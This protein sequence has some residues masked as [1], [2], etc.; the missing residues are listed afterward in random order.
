MSEIINLFLV[1]ALFYVIFI[2][3]TF[4]FWKN[5]LSLVIV[6]KKG[7]FF[8]MPVRFY[9]VIYFCI[10]NRVFNSVKYC[11]KWNSFKLKNKWKH[12]FLIVYVKTNFLLLKHF[13]NKNSLS[14]ANIKGVFFQSKKVCLFIYFSNINR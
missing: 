6:I 2:T 4:F 3:E 12:F 7:I 5:Y 8:F 9:F 1:F 14:L 10:F 13:V 11:Q